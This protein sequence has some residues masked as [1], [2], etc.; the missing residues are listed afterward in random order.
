MHIVYISREYPPMQRMGGIASYIKETA[1]ALVN[2]GHKVTVISAAED[3]HKEYSETINGVNVIRL[4]GADFIVDGVEPN[5]IKL[6]KLR[7]LYRFKSYRKRIRKALQELKDIDVIEVAEYGAESYLLDNISV[8]ICVRLHTGTLLDRENAG[9]KQFNWKKPWEYWIGKKEFECIS[10]AKYI[11]S[12]SNALKD[13]TERYVPNFKADTK[14]IYNPIDTSKWI[15]DKTDSFEE[16]T[17]LFVGTVAAAKGVGDLVDACR[18][19]IK[20]G[21]KIKLIIAGKLGTYGLS[22]KEEIEANNETWCE[23]TGHISRE[24]LKILY[25]RAKISC[26]PSWWENLPM[27]CLEAMTLGNVVIASKQGGMAEIITDGVDGFL[28]EPQSPERIRE[29]ISKAISLS[30][31]DT[32]CMSAN[33]RKTIDNKFSTEIIINQLENFYKKIISENEN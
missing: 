30:Y 13:W 4:K 18:L 22:L 21:K 2:R 1:E 23:F 6:K 28:V 16:N 11:T 33:A 3:T 20:E 15:K 8:P 5:I 12:C 31:G 17:I 9:I 7:C 25:S 26:F 19:L 14:V 32:T 27:V 29:K 10:K 24:E